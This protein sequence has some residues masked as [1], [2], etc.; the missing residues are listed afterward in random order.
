MQT[1]LT[2]T[3]AHL[4]LLVSHLSRPLSIL[5]TRLVYAMIRL[6][7]FHPPSATATTLSLLTTPGAL[8]QTL[9]MARE[10]M[11]EITHDRWDYSIWGSE[12]AG[13]SR[14]WFYFGRNDHWVAEETREAI[15]K[16]RGRGMGE[17]WKPRM[18][19]DEGGVPHGF[20]MGESWSGCF[21]LGV[22][23]VCGAEC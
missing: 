18:V 20:C 5:P 21:F 3:G 11:A 9:S 7:T 13:V 17:E 6:V 4:P 23:G 14:L 2:L 22:M 8:F 16:T 19:L 10:E 12:K 15:M 1:L